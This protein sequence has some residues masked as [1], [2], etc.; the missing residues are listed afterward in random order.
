MSLS[1]TSLKHAQTYDNMSDAQKHTFISRAYSKE[2]SSYREISDAVGTYPN[3]IRRDAVRLGITS[4]DKSKAQSVAIT[5]GRHKHPTKCTHRSIDTKIK[6][7]EGRAKAWEELTPA[8]RKRLSDIGK[9]QWA[10][11]SE[12]DKEAFQ[13]ASGDAIR[14]ASVEGSKLEKFLHQE[15]I[16]AGYRVEFHKERLIKNERL[17]IDL[18]LP[19]MGVAIE[20]DGPSHFSPIWGAKALARNQRADKQKT[21]LLLGVGA[22]MLRVRQSKTLSQKFKRTILAKVIETLEQISKKFPELSNRHIILGD[23]N[24]EV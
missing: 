23:I 14:K 11:M 24:N 8:E 20:V 17:Q 19:N 2:D 16:N 5:S 15:L 4:R 1:A 12:E 21:G 9:Q 3:K 10:D 6:I 22:I 7:S 13:K 18:W